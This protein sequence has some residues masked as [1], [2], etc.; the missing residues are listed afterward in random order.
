M[1]RLGTIGRAVLVLWI[2]L[3][4]AGGV[5]L[6]RKLDGSHRATDAQERTCTVAPVRP[7]VGVGVASTL[8]DEIG[9]TDWG[10]EV[11]LTAHRIQQPPPGPSAMELISV[12]GTA[13]EIPRTD[14]PTSMPIAWLD[15]SER[16]RVLWAEG[17][18]NTP[19]PAVPVRRVY[20]AV[21]EGDA[22]SAPRLV[23]ETDSRFLW[24]SDQVSLAAFGAE[25][26]PAFLAVPTLGNGIRL[27][28]F[29]GSDW[30]VLDLDA[31]RSTGGGY[32]NL[33][34]TK[35]GAIQLAYIGPDPGSSV[36]D[37]NS[38]LA[39]RS[40][41]DGQSWSAPLV[42]QRSGEVGAYGLAAASDSDGRLHLVWGRSSQAGVVGAS[43]LW[44]AVSDD[45]GLTWSS[46]SEIA[47]VAQLLPGS[48][49]DLRL[50][51]LAGGA[52]VLMFLK[53]SAERRIYVSVR[54]NGR[55]QGP[56]ALFSESRSVADFA[57]QSDLD[58]ILR[59]AAMLVP[60]RGREGLQLMFGMFHVAC[61][62]RD[63]SDALPAVASNLERR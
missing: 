57:V 29:A 38:V 1:A 48:I 6:E 36:V 3:T 13:L 7:L 22:W 52:T 46:P 26:G 51:P 44:H 11:L 8:Y 40:T 54:S 20:E 14:V 43:S 42:I 19:G 25:R 21:R 62:A 47:G 56:M 55:W 17:D 33:T 53:G 16:L 12:R 37:V 50:V 9:I 31:G 41:D 23:L 60:A 5:Y 15:G 4:T 39:V 49:R 32:S 34:L 18:A 24:R 61:P 35:S 2:M 30:S 45:E 10:D 27:A 28:R 63:L 59:V 58:G